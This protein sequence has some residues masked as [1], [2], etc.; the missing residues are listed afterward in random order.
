MAVS[1]SPFVA[2]ARCNQKL[3]NGAEA[4]MDEQKGRSSSYEG[5][6]A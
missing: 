5:D 4:H 6:N 1:S 3:L 2:V